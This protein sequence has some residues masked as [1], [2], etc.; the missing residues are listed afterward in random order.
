MTF[1]DAD[2]VVYLLLGFMGVYDDYYDTLNLVA[3]CWYLG[4][5]LWI[6]GGGRW[7]VGFWCEWGVV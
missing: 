1:D 5:G 4:C 2:F 7:L 3:S 6:W